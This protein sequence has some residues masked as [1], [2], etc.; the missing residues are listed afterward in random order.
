V[1]YFAA[2][3]FLTVLP[4]LRGRAAGAFGVA[5]SVGFFPLV[6]MTLGVLLVGLD[7]IL[8]LL[9][10]VS[11]VNVLLL[12]ALALL[13]G[14]LHLDGLID[15]CDALGGPRNAQER[16]R[17]MDDVHAG[18]F[19]V[20][21]AVFFL[22]VKYACLGELPLSHRAGGLLLAPTLSRW[23]LVYVIHSFPSAKPEGLGRLVK[24]G[25]SARDLVFASATTL[26]VSMAVLQ[27]WGLAMMAAAWL[28]A[29]ALGHF[30]SRRFAGLTGDS[31]GAIVE[32]T[33]VVALLI[34]AL[35]PLV[36]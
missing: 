32:I 26:A 7:S 14:L 27:A 13:T 34:L 6:G 4:S 28:A 9:L 19:G 35:P 36:G 31:Y 16:W 3:G 8:R 25:S 30:L 33:E 24:L 15:T 21:G 22:L 5:R 11:L 29:V 18:S 12:L 10:P 1:R 17:I 2:L 23:A 20:V